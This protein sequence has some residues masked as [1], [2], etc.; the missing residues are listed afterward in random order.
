MTPEDVRDRTAQRW[1]GDV[2][3][4]LSDLVAIPA[5]SPAYDAGWRSRGA[6]HSAAA[7]MATWITEAVAG[8]LAAHA[9]H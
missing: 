3:P 1:A 6:L 5:V 7:H 2:L 4:G 9:R 8:V